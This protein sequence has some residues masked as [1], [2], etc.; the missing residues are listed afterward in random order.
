MSSVLLDLDLG[1]RRFG[2]ALEEANTSPTLLFLVVGAP[3][4]GH[5]L[6]QRAITPSPPGLVASNGP[7]AHA[8]GGCDVTLSLSLCAKL[9]GSDLVADVATSTGHLHDS[10]MAEGTTKAVIRASTVR[11]SEQ[12]A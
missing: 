11:W 7:C 12:W 2:E 8:E 9:K 10:D 6:R 5:D 4:R 3:Q 1:S